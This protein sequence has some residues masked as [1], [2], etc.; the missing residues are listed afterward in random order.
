MQPSHATDDVTSATAACGATPWGAIDLEPFG[1]LGTPVFSGESCAVSRQRWAVGHPELAATHAVRTPMAMFPR[2]AFVLSLGHGP[3]LVVDSNTVV[4][5][6][7]GDTFQVHAANAGVADSDLLIVAPGALANALAT[8]GGQPGHDRFPSRVML[9]TP[10][11]HLAMHCLATASPRFDARSKGIERQALDLLAEVVRSSLQ[12]VDE[13]QGARNATRAGAAVRRA[14]ALLAARVGSPLS[15]EALAA[16]VHLSPF[17]LARVF[18][19]HCG[20]SIHA[21][22][23]RLTLAHSLALLRQPRMSVAAVSNRLGFCAH[24]H[25]SSTFRRHFGISPRAFVGTL[26]RG[27]NSQVRV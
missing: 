23:M 13:G 15:L 9:A 1:S 12:Q 10:R 14:R 16:E 22:W 4:L 26:R 17:H 8:Q 20:T 3:Q 18:K 7:A 2:T 25:F 11:V 19:R 21:Y 5:L 6:D 27:G 24:S